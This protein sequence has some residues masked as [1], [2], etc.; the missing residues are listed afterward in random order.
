[1]EEIME[2]CPHCSKCNDFLWNIEDDGY[3]AHCLYCGEKLLICSECP[4]KH[5]CSIDSKTG[6]C[7]MTR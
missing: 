2:I 6:K 5:D 1:M 4:K 3:Q 7:E